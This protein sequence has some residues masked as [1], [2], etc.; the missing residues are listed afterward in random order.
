MITRILLDTCVIRNFIHQIG[1]KLDVPALLP[2]LWKYRISLADGTTAELMNQFAEKRI[3][4]QDWKDR[5]GELD[6]I[7]DPRFPVFLG[8]RELAA[9]A[10]LQTDLKFDASEVQAHK[11]A[12]WKLLRDATDEIKLLAGVNYKDAQGD[13][14]LRPDPIQIQTAMQQAR[15]TWISYVDKMKQLEQQTPGLFSSLA[16]TKAYLSSGLGSASTDP[17]DLATRLDAVLSIQAELVY[18]SVNSPNP[19]NPSSDKRRGDLF[20]MALLYALPLPVIIITADKPFLNRVKNAKTPDAVQLIDTSQFNQHVLDD[21]LEKLL[22]HH[23][24]PAAQQARWNEAAYFRWIE[25][26]SPAGDEWNDWFATE[27]IA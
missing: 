21:D 9:L 16:K 18:M 6:K 11:Q 12:I 14:A 13:K 7:L 4:F 27:P 15:Q 24:T 10:G 22:I 23:R 2:R 19:Y 8:G 1:P 3:S 5:I 25:R 26:G 17:P 20:D